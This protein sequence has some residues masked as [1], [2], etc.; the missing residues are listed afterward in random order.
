MAGQ[1][2]VPLLPAEKVQY[3]KTKPRQNSSWPV[4]IFVHK[5]ARHLKDLVSSQHPVEPDS[6]SLPPG[7]PGASDLV[8]SRS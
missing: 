3:P 5:N 4:M 2:N 6:M 1:R 7:Q 8:K